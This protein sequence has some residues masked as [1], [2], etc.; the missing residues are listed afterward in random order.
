MQNNIDAVLE[1]RE[2]FNVPMFPHINHPNFGWAVTVED[3]ISLKGE[4]FFEVYNG[5]PLVHNYGDSARMSTEMMWDKINIAYAGRNQPLMFGLA[6]D[7]SHNYHQSGAAFSN[8]G[9]GWV[10]VQAESLRSESLIN[11]MEA[12]QFYSSTGVT[13]KELSF[14]NGNIG[15]EVE[16][17]PEINY[18]IEFIG[19]N[20]GSSEATVLQK[21]NG[22]RAT[23]KVGTDHIFVRARVT[24]TKLKE[25]PFQEGDFEM[26]WTQPVTL[27]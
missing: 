11:A 8:A 12:G 19:A 2:K 5:H 13:L 16:Q 7:D 22:V 26:A 9:R 14:K 15:I 10:I 20:K 17:A 4:R 1:Q 27:N 25:N 18:T 24:T 21:T 6:T 3:M 23:F